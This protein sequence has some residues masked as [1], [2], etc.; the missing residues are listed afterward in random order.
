MW[1]RQTVSIWCKEA[2]G[3]AGIPPVPQPASGTG[4]SPRQE[5]KGLSCAFLVRSPAAGSPSPSGHPGWAA[6]LPPQSTAGYK[7]CARAQ[8]CLSGLWE[9]LGRTDFHSCTC[10][11]F[12]SIGMCKVSNRCSIKW[13]F[14][15]LQQVQR[16]TIKIGKFSF[17]LKKKKPRWEW[18]FMC[19]QSLESP[20]RPFTEM[21]LK[22]P[23]RYEPPLR[24]N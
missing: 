14:C 10:G 5:L 11:L 19:Q 3:G 20:T 12:S 9:H 18:T 16:Y 1:K 22:P 17:Q 8:P 13:W 6:R 7:W 2:S 24:S 15:A 4:L 23:L 21:V